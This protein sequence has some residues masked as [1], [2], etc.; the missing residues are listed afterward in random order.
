MN[1]H[2]QLQIVHPIINSFCFPI[3]YF[4]NNENTSIF[5]Y[6]NGTNN[7]K[8]WMDQDNIE[9]EFKKNIN[10]IVDGLY[11]ELNAYEPDAI[12]VAPSS[13]LINN[14]VSELLKHKLHIENDLSNLLSKKSNV[15]MGKNSELSGKDF[16]KEI[17]CSV[18]FSLKNR[19]ILIFDEIISKGRTISAIISTLLN[20]NDLDL[21]NVILSALYCFI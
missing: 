13:K 8:G 1:K 12:L 2:I 18:N 7:P 11:N 3:V 6:V 15:K 5:R 21:D 4:D 14:I 10:S 9:I 20:N 19:K 17:N 16:M